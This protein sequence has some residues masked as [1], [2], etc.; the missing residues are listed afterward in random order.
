MEAKY[1]YLNSLVNET[2]AE[3]AKWPGINWLNPYKSSVSQ[4]H[5]DTLMQS[6]GSLFDKTK[7]YYNQISKGCSLCGLGKW[8]CLFITNKCNAG[9]FYCPAP[10][11]NDEK[12]STQGMEFNDAVDY[13]HY[14]KYFGFKAV[15]F[16]G[17][18]PLLFFERTLNYLKT[19]RMICNPDLYTWVYTN[20][21]L[22][23]TDYLKKLANAGLDELRFDIGATDYNIDKVILAKD[24]IPTVTI[25]IPAVPEMKDK[26]IG[27]LPE[28]VQAGVQNLN[29]HQLRLTQHNAPEFIKRAYTV[30][31]YERP[32]ILESEIAALEI[33]EAARRQNIELGIN[34]CSFHF[35]H[36]FQKAG[37]R[38]IIGEKLYPNA[39]LTKNGFIRT[40]SNEAITYKSIKLSNN[41]SD[42]TGSDHIKLAGKYYNYHTKATH[43]PV[44]PDFL[45][46]VTSFL[47]NIP[48]EA[49]SDPLLFSIWQFENIERGLRDY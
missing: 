41:Q 28:I 14:I 7:P 16:S 1:T 29:L 25:E 39:V 13:A 31:P 17:G 22:V 23:K 8:S 43:I 21:K 27:M 30:I 26:I 37:F 2:K 44:P 40:L 11:K 32:I 3:F 45:N 4:R 47:S 5:R 9:C 48:A 15:S 18:E 42:I 38:K 46:K 19:I 36:H 6:H 34:Y 24:I 12:P 49:P 10:Q 20:G 33:M 35:K